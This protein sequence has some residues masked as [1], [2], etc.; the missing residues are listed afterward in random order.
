M[1]GIVY[2]INLIKTLNFLNDDDKPE[3]VVFYRAELKKYLEQVNYPYLKLVEWNFNSIYKG[4]L[5]SWILQKNVFVYDILMNY[6]LDGLYPLQDYP[7]KTKTKTKLV[8]W[9]AD[10]QHRHYP[11]FF[12]RFQRAGRNIRTKLALINNDNLVLSSMDAFNDLKRFYRLRKGLRVHVFHFVSVLDEEENPEIEHL[13]KKYNLPDNYFLIS[14]QFHKHKNHRV[15]LLTLI[16][17]NELG[18]KKHFAFTGKFPDQSDSPYLNELHDIIEQHNLNGQISMLGLIPRRDQ[19]A[20]MKYSQ[21]VIQPSLF[22]GWSTVIEDAKSLQVPV[23]ASNLSVNIEQL[24]NN[25]IY[26]EPH[27]VEELATILRN[28]PPR[29]INDVFYQQYRDRIKTA[30]NELLGILK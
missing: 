7:V 14:N 9:C 15:L 18:I 29:N 5:L 2:I 11:E 24:G 20:L 8:S 22:E 3:V 27:N 28:Y 1:G 13:K 10:F 26:F 16:R 30:A 23:V 17:L 21:A 4:Y 12:T 6:N 25:G 19:L